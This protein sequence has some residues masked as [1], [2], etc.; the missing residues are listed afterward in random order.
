MLGL[1]S[2]G[3]CGLDL[4]NH[5]FNFNFIFLSGGLTAAA[6]RRAGPADLDRR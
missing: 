1:K 3:W 5:L 4:A 2:T 6:E